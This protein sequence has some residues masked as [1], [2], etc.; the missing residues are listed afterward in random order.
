MPGIVFTLHSKVFLIQIK[1]IL[2]ILIVQLFQ[3]RIWSINPDG[4][5]NMIVNQRQE[6]C[7]VE[8]ATIFKLSM[9]CRD[10]YNYVNEG[11]SPSQPFPDLAVA[12]RLQETLDYIEKYTVT[13]KPACYIPHGE[14][15]LLP[16]EAALE[17]LG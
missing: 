17:V 11:T 7:D 16:N 1:R 15:K 3:A 4:S 9:L 6:N 10:V 12:T 8:L 13:P 14:R 5:E 2:H